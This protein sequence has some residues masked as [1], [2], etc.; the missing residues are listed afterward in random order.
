MPDA[1]PLDA[2]FGQ[3]PNLYRDFIDFYGLFWE[4]RLVDPVLLELCR[5]RV[6]Q[7]VGCRAELAIR[8]RPAL[9]AGLDEARI[10]A[11]EGWRGAPVFSDGER[12]CLDLTERFV[13]APH[14]ISDEGAAAV[15]SF[16]G[17]PGMVA[18]IEALA[19]FD[20]FARFRAI[21]GV[22]PASDG[23]AVVD[24]PSPGARSLY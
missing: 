13:Q 8:Y 18:L 12:A 10:A 24:G 16:L 1:T 14:S 3:R 9:E 19:L 7:L 23:I 15:R 21:L 17:A 2:V 4:R 11:L 22:E 6:A 20:G 5:L